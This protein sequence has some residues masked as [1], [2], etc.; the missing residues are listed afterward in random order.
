M[1]NKLHA[2][3]AGALIATVL[4]PVGAAADPG[5]CTWTFG[6][7]SAI[8]NTLYPDENAE[9]W[10]GG[11]GALV[12][13]FTYRITGEFPHARF[14]SFNV[15]NGAPADH[16]FDEA[17]VPD[18]GSSNP[19]LPGADRTVQ[20]RRYT[21]PL[22]PA[23]PP[24]DP[25]QRQPG[26]LYMGGG[27]HDTPNPWPYMV[28]RIYVPDSG[29]GHQGGV[30]LPT[31]EIVD[32][33]GNVV[34]RPL[35]S[36][37]CEDARR[38]VTDPFAAPVHAAVQSGDPPSL[39]AGAP[40]AANPPHFGVSTGLTDAVY[41]RVTG[42]SFPFRGGPASNEDNTYASASISVANGRVLAIRAKAPTF[43]ATSSGETVMGTG[44]L[45]YWSFCQ[46]DRTLRY[47][48]CV[49]DER[50]QPDGDGSFVIAISGQSDRPANAVN[51]L[52]WGAEPEGQL[53]YRQMLP[54][55]DFYPH[56]LRYA[57]DSGQLDGD[58][59]A[60]VMGPYLPVG[61]YCSKA[62]FEQDRCGL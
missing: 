9:Y 33:L 43:P 26:A 53:I 17:I 12:P 58:A 14:I 8:F 50:V 34:T 36:L 4:H 16:I 28:Y 6:V 2:L 62:Q 59:L 22:L 60:A 54:S 29:T 42:E 15:Y 55:T 49:N 10:A 57:Y 51:W 52:P 19:F 41:A 35:E 48:A 61:V 27:Q 45:R 30:P 3:V 32:P 21:I 44:E 39:P 31:I 46:N 25:A 1:S 47:V 23:P 20:N 40:G 38:S 11:T 5:G 24:A 37:S 56:S 18:P 7:D 13:G